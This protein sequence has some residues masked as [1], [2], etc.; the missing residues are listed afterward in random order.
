MKPLIRQSNPEYQVLT[1]KEY[2]FMTLDVVGKRDYE[3]PDQ[4]DYEKAPGTV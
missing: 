3:R 2:R 4:S 1:R